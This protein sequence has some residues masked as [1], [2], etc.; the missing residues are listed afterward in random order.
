MEYVIEV[1]DNMNRNPKFGPTGEQLRGRWTASH[2]AA[3]EAHSAIKAISSI[4]I[5]NGICLGIDR[6]KRLGR[7]FDPLRETAEGKAIWARVQPLL[8]QYNEIFDQGMKPW[9]QAVFP[10]LDDNDVKTWFYWMR[11]LLDA[12]QAF[13]Q[14]DRF[15]TMDE[16]KKYPGGVR[17][18][19]WSNSQE[20]GAD[21]LY[22]VVEA[23][24]KTA[25]T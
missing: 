18:N 13:L 10:Q 25:K 24:E 16:I 2:V 4:P 3:I 7:R 1:G 11:R 5:I 8:D 19:F 22:Y 23:T 21:A 6:E 20:A 14:S 12:K 15:P 17:K 9:D